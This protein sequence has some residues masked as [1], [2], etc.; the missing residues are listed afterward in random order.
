MGPGREAPSAEDLQHKGSRALPS[1][2]R[3][4]RCDSRR[5]G[6]GQAIL[7]PFI[8][9]VAILMFTS[10]RVAVA[11]PGT[12]AAMQA[13]QTFRDCPNCPEMLV[14]P[15]G[16]FQMGATGEEL[17]LAGAPNKYWFKSQ[18]V[19]HPVSV[20]SFAIGRYAVTRGEFAAFVRETGY[21][22][23][24]C[25]IYQENTW[26]QSETNNWRNPGF[27]Q[28]DRH[29]VVCVSWEDAQRYVSWLNGKAA[30]RGSASKGGDGPYRLPS[31]AE[32]E[33]AARA[34]TTS[35][36]FWG[37]D[38]STQC[39]FANGGD[40]TTKDRYP[41]WPAPAPPTCRDGYVWTAPVGS[42]RPNPWGLYDMLGNVEQWVEDCW[43]LNYSGA[44]SDGSAWRSGSCEERV[45]RGGGWVTP[46]LLLMVSMRGNLN[47][48]VRFGYVGFRVARTLR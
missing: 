41:G 13:G 9:L 12:Q 22:P 4:D 1:V 26:R 15:A 19:K 16:E 32:W 28:T 34:G 7:V 48:D 33:Y 38:I 3:K 42:F 45:S 47:K 11:E 23:T 31:E 35:A 25:G 37:D 36:R 46:P 10:G 39:D 27:D 24:G 20:G 43:N 29:P 21:D 8:L 6:R 44:P 14:L 5:M 40:L 18:Q 17:V 2:T 30:G